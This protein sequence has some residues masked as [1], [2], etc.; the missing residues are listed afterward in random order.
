MTNKT[1]W[2]RGNVPSRSDDS[3]FKSYTDAKG[4]KGEGGLCGRDLK[5]LDEKREEA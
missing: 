3:L 5:G 2:N 4:R 1:L